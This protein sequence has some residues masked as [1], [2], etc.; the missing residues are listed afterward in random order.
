MIAFLGAAA[1]VIVGAVFGRTNCFVG[2]APRNDLVVEFPGAM[3]A[4]KA[5]LG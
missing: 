1:P 3:A 5:V 4:R 2:R